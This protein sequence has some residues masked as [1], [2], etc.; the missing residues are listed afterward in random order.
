[1]LL[2]QVLVALTFVACAWADCRPA[3]TV[4]AHREGDLFN[5]AREAD[6]GDA[7]AEQLEPDLRLIQA[8]S[9]T[10]FLAEL[11]K[12][13]LGNSPS[14]GIQFRFALADSP[15]A[16]A[17]VLPGGRVYITRK[18]VAAL[19]TPD[20]LAAVVGHEM[21][22]A[23]AHQST[24]E[25]SAAMRRLL[26]IDAVNT[27]ED[28]FHDYSLL[29]GAYQRSQEAQDGDRRMHQDQGLAD[30]ISVELL[31]AA[32]YDADALATVLD[33]IAGLNGRHGSFFSDVFGLSKPEQKR[34]RDLQKAVS[35]LPDTCPTHAPVLTNS[36]FKAWQDRVL[37][38]LGS[39]EPSKLNGLLAVRDLKPPL[40]NALEY[41]HFSPDGK[42]A[43]AQDPATIHVLSI[44]PFAPLFDIAAPRA[45][46]PQFSP[47]SAFVSFVSD[48]L[49]YE[50]WNISERRQ[51]EVRELQVV[52][53]CWIH[54]LS[55]AGDLFACLQPDLTLVVTRT[56][57]DT[58]VFKQK[59]DQHAPSPLD[60]KPDWSSLAFGLIA[61]TMDFSPGGSWLLLTRTGLFADTLLVDLRTSKAVRLSS[62]A[63]MNL[64]SSFVF[65]T[66]DSVLVTHHWQQNASAL[67]QLP[68]GDVATRVV[69]PSGEV[70]PL[71]DAR[72]VLVKTDGKWAAIVVNLAEK[73]VVL[74]SLVPALDIRDD[75][76]LVEDGAGELTLRR[77]KA[78]IGAV[79]VGSPLLGDTTA[80]AFSPTLDWIAL[81]NS[82]RAGAW[83]T[84]T[85][86]GYPLPPFERAAFAERAT[87]HVATATKLDRPSESVDI[88]LS[89]RAVTKSTRIP[90]TDAKPPV[91]FWVGATRIVVDRQDNSITYT[92][93]R[94]AGQ[95]IW[96]ATFKSPAFGARSFSSGH[97]ALIC[98]AQSADGI[99]VI[100]NTPELRHEQQKLGRDAWLVQVRDT[101]SGKVEVNRLVTMD[102][103]TSVFV[104]NLV[105]EKSELAVAGNWLV[106]PQ[107]LNRLL[108]EDWQTGAVTTQTFGHAIA[109]N[110]LTTKLVV[111]N[112]ER[113]LKLFTLQSGRETEPLTFP[114]RVV[115]AG[116]DTE[117]KHLAVVTADQK[118]YTLQV[119]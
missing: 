68:G 25:I 53:G 52:P 3:N 27:R 6:L 119:P 21:G 13:L 7:V 89:T 22:H 61:P 49:R 24:F 81:S 99:D 57:S 75:L 62:R 97:L 95:K 8:P 26:K 66:D 87:L 11:S 110:E 60:S 37:K 29:M 10:A 98:P 72:Y 46:R 71:S 55:P 79:S 67:V 82:A 109:F 40:V 118:V 74:G 64:S 105:M 88:D 102:R 84:H 107:S 47:D 5:D 48:S 94:D 111:H 76:R 86:N 51:V 20:Q 41:V 103:K 32:G 15:Y 115:A 42:Y 83:D 1:M 43:L 54:R 69:I 70:Q 78:A 34:I 39:E 93:Y 100:K 12:Q 45:A 104:Q 77:A 108:I 50:K 112:R 9:E 73:A 38:L 80:E 96:S 4:Y 106:I 17:F 36:D 30:R 56:D 18:L 117:G 2:R 101:G 85:G 28:V 92:G 23:L 58:V 14:T 35:M 63:R 16:N 91:H 90:D 114:E 59:I 33:R 44:S 65:L 113:E 116:F 19:Q 31:T